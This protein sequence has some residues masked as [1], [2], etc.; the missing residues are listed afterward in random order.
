MITAQVESFLPFLEEV[1]PL[2]QGHW[3]E[4]ALDKDKHE[5]ELD[6]DYAEYIRRDSMGSVCTVTLR[7]DGVLVGYI[8]G[9]I[10]TGLHYRRCLTYIM[11]ILYVHKDHRGNGGGSLLIDVLEK[12]QKRRGVHRSFYGSKLHKDIE[13]LFK[14]HNCHEIEHHFSKW[15]GE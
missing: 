14:K 3:E 7:C 6:P 9:F 1:K 2:L 4:L 11:D 8:V 5:A 15:L 13:W 12:E 10:N